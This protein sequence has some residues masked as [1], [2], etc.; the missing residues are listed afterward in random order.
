MKSICIAFTEV[1]YFVYRLN[2]DLK[3]LYKK[4]KHHAKYF[5]FFIRS[6]YSTMSQISLFCRYSTLVDKLHLGYTLLR[7]IDG[8][9]LKI[10]VY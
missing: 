9:V 7:N 6:L 10:R 3:K 1:I 8:L 2:W 5:F 4:C